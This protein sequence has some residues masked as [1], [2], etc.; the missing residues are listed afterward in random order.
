MTV[1]EIHEHAAKYSKSY[2][3]EKSGWKTDTAAMERKTVLRL[4]LRKW[5][6]LD[7]ADIAMLEEIESEPDAIDVEPSDIAKEIKEPAK[8]ETEIMG[9]LG[10][11]DEQVTDIMWDK[12]L[13]LCQR[14]DPLNIP[15][16]PAHRETYTI[17]TLDAAYKELKGFVEDAEEQARAS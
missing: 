11:G 15:Y 5:G 7:P 2:N 12:W 16:S 1:E 6:Y 4:L 8:S 3:N 9:D 14:A 10:F 13:R 17:A